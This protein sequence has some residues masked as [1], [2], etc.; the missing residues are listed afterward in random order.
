MKKLILLVPVILLISLS[1][2]S[3]NPKDKPET[4]K[5]INTPSTIHEVI[6]N[7]KMDAGTYTYINVTE[8]DRTYWIAVTKMEVNKGDTLFYSQS[9]EMKNFESQALNKTFD[10]IL[11]I[12]KIST[13]E[14]PASIVPHP[15]IKPAEKTEVKVNRQ[16]GSI[17]IK[18]LFANKNSY[19]GKMII[20]EGKVTKLN[21]EIMHRN[22]IH[23]QDGTN[24]NGDYDLLITSNDLVT[25]GSYVIMEGVVA[26][27]KDF[28][29]GYKYPILVENAIL[30]RKNK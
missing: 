2:C 23:I 28:G 7:E 5:Q 21:K 13:P 22:W 12:D 3:E 27:D 29:A 20:V 8:K 9:M 6:V 26:T 4:E 30:I 24:F 10:S 16:K 15:E 11:F 18:D 1:A 25:V 14:K 19:K 17:T